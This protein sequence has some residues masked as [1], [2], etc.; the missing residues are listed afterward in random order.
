MIITS[1]SDNSGIQDAANVTESTPFIDNE[2]GF[3]NHHFGDHISTF[4]GLKL[5]EKGE[6]KGVNTYG[7]VEGI[8]SDWELENVTLNSVGYF[9]KHDSLCQIMLVCNA[10]QSGELLRIAKER[11]GIYKQM[12]PDKKVYHWKGKKE[13]VTYMPPS[14]G[15]W[16]N[17]S[18]TITSVA[19]S[20]RLKKRHK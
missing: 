13:M 18:L 9:F 15:D 8:Q 3:R 19:M 12:V 20:A 17:S 7:L 1:C 5:V 11:Y 4:E 16:E 14:S 2:N 6:P 10:K